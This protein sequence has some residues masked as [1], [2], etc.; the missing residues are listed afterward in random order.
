MV[1]TWWCFA[2]VYKKIVAEEG[3]YAGQTQMSEAWAVVQECVDALKG[4]IGAVTQVDS[5][6]HTSLNR[7]TR[8]HLL[9][10]GQC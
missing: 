3:L 5:L 4:E 6:Q 1:R 8:A 9:R 10:L 2:A 7:S